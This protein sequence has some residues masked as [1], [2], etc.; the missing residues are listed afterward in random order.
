[1][2]SANDTVLW[3]QFKSGNRDAF[4]EIYRRNIDA[5]IGYGTKLCQDPELLKDTLQDLF[6]ELWNSRKNL[7]QPQ[8]VSFYLAKA[9]RY[10]LFRA[11]KMRPFLQA[12]DPGNL[13]DPVSGNNRY[14]DSIETEIIDKELIETQIRSLRKSI[15]ALSRRQ[16]EAIQLKFYQGFSN[17]QIAELMEMN[18]QSVSNLLHSALLRIK[19]NMKSVPVF[20]AAFLAAVQLFA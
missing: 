16:Q 11:L 13:I 17:Q 10:K 15:G 19:T 8:S 12:A 1:M 5:L 3:S 2:D 6:V 20:S 14:A 18:Y 7:V 9:L 4:A